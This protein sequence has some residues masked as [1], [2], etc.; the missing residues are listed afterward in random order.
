M[1][2]LFFPPPHRISGDVDV[3]GLVVATGL[4]AVI[5]IS[6]SVRGPEGQVVTQELHD[7]RRVLVAVLVQSVQ[8]GDSIVKCLNEE[9][10]KKISI[11][12]SY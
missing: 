8:L 5:T 12:I 10:Q 4:T 1:W 3:V 11:K 7:Q 9:K 6:G 2:L